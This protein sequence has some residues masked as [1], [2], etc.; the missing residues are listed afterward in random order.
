VS[1]E[2][3]NETVWQVEECACPLCGSSAARDT[4][5]R[6]APF[7]VKRCAEC[8]HWF[9][10]PRL[11]PEAADRFYTSDQ[12]FNGSSGSGYENYATQKRS[13]Q[14]TFSRLM[15]A[16][17][18][19]GATGGDLL[20]VGSGPGYLL[21]VATPHFASVEGVELSERTAREAEALSGAQVYRSVDAIDDGKA[22]DCIIATHVIEHIY[23]P[24]TFTR[25]LVARLRPGGFLILAAPHMNS[26]LRYLMG[27]AWP[28]W[29]YPEHV[30]F[31]DQKTLPD[32]MRRVGLQD[33]EIVPYPHAFPLPLILS[34]F[35]LSAPRWMQRFD[36]TLPT[37]T[38][39]VMARKVDGS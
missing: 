9:L 5:Y 34:K 23:E 24:V 4:R 8:A 14:A 38:I 2:S 21:E 6:Q 37:T 25:D 10:S 11:V 29:K 33:P 35:G 36:L 31:F 12:Y 15:D 32:L 27:G 26:P 30:S 17:A 7:A 19:R 3:A 22:Y 1:F 13:L 16:V 39:C 28:S 20:E 18:A